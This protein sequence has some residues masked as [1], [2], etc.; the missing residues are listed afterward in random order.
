MFN[1][2]LVLEIDP[3]TVA[4]RV[5]MKSGD[6]GFELNLT[7]QVRFSFPPNCRLSFQ[8]FSQAFASAKETLTRSLLKS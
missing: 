4:G 1:Y 8:T 6:G 2:R 3:Q 5:S 7:E